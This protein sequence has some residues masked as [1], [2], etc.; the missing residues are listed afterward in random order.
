MG[1]IWNKIKRGFRAVG[2]GV[3]K[4]VGFY[5]KHKDKI[6]SVASAVGGRAGGAISKGMQYADKARSVAKAGGY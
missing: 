4:A 3:K 1:R 2:R 5:D 6:A